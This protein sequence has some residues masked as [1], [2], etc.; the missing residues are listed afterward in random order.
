MRERGQVPVVPL[1]SEP[2]RKGM[3]VHR[4]TAHARVA[5]VASDEYAACAPRKDQR[6]RGAGST[7][8]RLSQAQMGVPGTHRSSTRFFLAGSSSLSLMKPS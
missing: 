3:P 1:D 2:R 5:L 4:S 7:L 8:A 6:A